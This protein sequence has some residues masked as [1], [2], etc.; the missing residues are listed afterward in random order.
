MTHTEKKILPAA[1]YSNNVNSA[2][3]WQHTNAVS[4]QNNECFSFKGTLSV[5]F[6]G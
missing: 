5:F 1:Y 2:T 6:G 4:H 3:N